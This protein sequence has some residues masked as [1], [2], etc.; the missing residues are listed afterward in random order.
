MCGVHLPEEGDLNTELVVSGKATKQELRRL[1]EDLWSVDHAASHA[2]ADDEYCQD[3]GRSIY[4]CVCPRCP[5]CNGTEGE[6]HCDV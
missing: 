5:V 4:A 3:C 6:C 2:D 1:Q